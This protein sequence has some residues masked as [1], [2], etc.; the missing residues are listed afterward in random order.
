MHSGP[1]WPQQESSSCEARN[2]Q[3]LF[4]PNKK[5]TPLEINDVVYMYVYVVLDL[6]IFG[7][8]FQGL[9]PTMDCKKST[10]IS[11]GSKLTYSSSEPG[12]F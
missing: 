1:M 7:A 10:T 9:T 2:G 3:N 12:P 8:R 4:S 6:F 5:T 11:S